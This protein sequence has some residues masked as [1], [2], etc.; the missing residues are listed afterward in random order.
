M[1]DIYDQKSMFSNLKVDCSSV[2]FVSAN[3]TLCVCVCVCVCV[4]SVWLVTCINFIS[5]L[6]QT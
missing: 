4:C 3:S 5:L 6:L 2:Y 1:L